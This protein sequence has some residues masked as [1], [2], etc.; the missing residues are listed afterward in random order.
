MHCILG[1]SFAIES[2]EIH[3]I[4]MLD[5]CISCNLSLYVLQNN[6]HPYYCRNPCQSI[7]PMHV[8]VVSA[9]NNHHPITNR[10]LRVRMDCAL[11]SII[12]IFPFFVYIE[13]I[14]WLYFDYAALIFH[15]WIHKS[16]ISNEYGSNYFNRT[17]F[18]IFIPLN[19][20]QS[21]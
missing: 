4:V 2:I 9:L 13:F 11:N 18:T 16:H 3:E 6:D 19:P 21:T 17:V 10:I 15:R 8:N 14:L 5:H 1:D 7:T 20:I 12:V